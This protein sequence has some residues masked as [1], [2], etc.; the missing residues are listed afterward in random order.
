MKGSRD[1]YRILNINSVNIIHLLHAFSK[2]LLFGRL[3][4]IIIKIKG[5]PL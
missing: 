1:K 4:P 5:N 3:V 2:I